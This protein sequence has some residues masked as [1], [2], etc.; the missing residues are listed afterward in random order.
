M[1]AAR[2]RQRNAEARA[3]VLH[4][5]AE[6][7]PGSTAPNKA[8]ESAD[9]HTSSGSGSRSS[10]SQISDSETESDSSSGSE[11][12]PDNG[13]PSSD[14]G[15]SVAPGSM[16]LLELAGLQLDGLDVLDPQQL[17]FQVC[18]RLQRTLSLRSAGCHTAS[19]AG[20]DPQSVIDTENWPTL[21]L[22][23]SWPATAVA[24]SRT[25]HRRSRAAVQGGPSRGSAPAATCP[26]PWRC[27][28]RWCTRTATCWPV[29][30]ARAARRWTSFPACWPAS[31]GPVALWLPS[32]A[33]PPW[34]H[35]A[36]LCLGLWS[37]GRGLAA[38]HPS[39][40]RDL[41]SELAHPSLAGVCRQ[42]QAAQTCQRSC[43]K[44][45]SALSLQFTAVSF[46]AA[47][48]GSSA[49]S[50]RRKQVT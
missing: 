13:R 12:A 3:A 5:H 19:C 21:W 49:P 36:C 48:E 1:E 41:L 29:C 45:H 14:R 16:R 31:A 32:G 33:G 38:A 10:S 35:L 40:P 15:F 47:V 11:P 26:G 9:E 30:A 7:Q 50:R 22:A 44:C 6:P 18:L 17:T 20:L 23:C 46:P 34:L 28:A 8:A 27:G 37:R 24:R 39:Q 25:T 2:A 4:S 43:S 42:V